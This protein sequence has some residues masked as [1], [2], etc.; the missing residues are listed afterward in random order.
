M[1]TTANNAGLAGPIPVKNVFHRRFTHA[2]SNVFQIEKSAN[3]FDLESDLAYKATTRKYKTRRET[4]IR[5][6][7]ASSPY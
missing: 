4:I 5:Y 1:S 6:F 2:T 7:L 3:F